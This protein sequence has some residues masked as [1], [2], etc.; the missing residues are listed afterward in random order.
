MSPGLE[1]EGE[2]QPGQGALTAAGTAC[3]HRESARFAGPVRCLTRS[4]GLS[5]V[6]SV[7]SSGPRGVSYGV[8]IVLWSPGYLVWSSGPQGVSFGVCMVVWLPGS[9]GVCVWCS[10]S[11][12]V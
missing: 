11:R 3:F 6:V 10:G 2:A 5:R 12:G 9:Y 7:W 1:E 8:C 4:T